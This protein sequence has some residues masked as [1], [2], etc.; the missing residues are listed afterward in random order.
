MSYSNTIGQVSTTT[1]L[2][3]LPLEFPDGSIQYTAGDSVVQTSY[4]PNQA[5]QALTQPNFSRVVYNNANQ[6]GGWY[7]Y[8]IEVSLI[9]NDTAPIAFSYFELN[10]DTAG[11]NFSQDITANF[12]LA[13]GDLISKV[14]TIPVK[15][16]GTNALTITFTANI[17]SGA[18]TTN[19]PNVSFRQNALLKL[20]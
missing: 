5:L 12:T 19:T 17:T 20:I 15:V 18:F 16:N 9:N 8:S 11:A 3:T 6:A 7:L 2:L 1:T 4:T 14:Y 13:V 10:V